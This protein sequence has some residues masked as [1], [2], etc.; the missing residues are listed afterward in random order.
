MHSMDKKTSQTKAFYEGEI[1]EL[2]ERI[3]A[4]A[5]G[6]LHIALFEHQDQSIAAAMEAASLSI[7]AELPLSPTTRILEV[8][9][10]LGATARLLAAKYGCRI[11]A[12]NIS[13]TQ[14]ASAIALAKRAGL[15]SLVSHEVCDYGALPYEDEAY[16]IYWC[17]ES[18]VHADDK[19]RVLGEA[20]RILR[21]GGYLALSD[22][23][24]VE[25]I[26][27]DLRRQIYE[28]IHVSSMWSGTQYR[29]AL[30]QCSFS[31]L[32][33]R[34][35][36]EHVAP[37]YRWVLK[38]LLGHRAACLNVMGEDAFRKMVD[39]FRLWISEAGR[40]KIGCFLFIARKPE[41]STI[42]R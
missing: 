24:L 31:I 28:R 12:T 14:I 3:W 42:P 25:D 37:T 15:D 22:L 18:L 23:T 7:A 8:A 34:D 27:P 41:S 17:Q 32:K 2:W 19:L 16:D 38:E 20:Y 10:G 21:P 4:P 29:M 26:A 36:S 35:W 5:R 33:I 1:V 6:H 13:E 9:C 39:D 11:S 30:E 40:N